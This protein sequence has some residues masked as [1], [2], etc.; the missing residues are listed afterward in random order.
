MQQFVEAIAKEREKTE[1]IV[2]FVVCL[3]LANTGIA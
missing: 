3:F 2:I 1:N